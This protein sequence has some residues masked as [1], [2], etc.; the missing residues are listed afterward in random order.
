MDRRRIYR[1][2]AET[3]AAIGAALRKHGLPLVELRVPADLARSALSAW[4]WEDEGELSRESPAQQLDRH[5][6]GALALIGAAISEQGWQG[7]DEV[8]V[9]L[10]PDLIGAALDAADDLLPD[11]HGAAPQQ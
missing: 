9:R 3:L 2:D 11:T 10:T 4:E 8:V 6:A 7:T 1:R 5:R